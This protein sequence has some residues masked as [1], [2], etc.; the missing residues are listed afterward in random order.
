M[1][2]VSRSA[3]LFWSRESDLLELASGDFRFEALAIAS[4]G[5]GVF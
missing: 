3:A 2:E 5:G 1:I 4:D